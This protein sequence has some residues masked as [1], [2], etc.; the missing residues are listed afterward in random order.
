MGKTL[1]ISFASLMVSLWQL[2][3]VATGIN[4]SDEACSVSVA[5]YTINSVYQKNL[6]LLFS[7][8]SSKTSTQKFYNSTIGDDPDKVYGLY[9]C[10]E[11]VSLEICRQCI[12]EATQKIV[13][14]CPLKK[15]AIVWY[16][17]CMLRYSKSSIF[18]LLDMSVHDYKHS[19]IG[20]SN[21]SQFSPVLASE[22]D[23]VIDQAAL[24]TSSGHFATRRARWS[25]YETVYC[26]AQCTP[27]LSGRDC[28]NCL[29]IALRIMFIANFNNSVAIGIFF[30]SCQLRYGRVQFYDDLVPKPPAPTS[31]SSP[32]T[33][34][35]PGKSKADRSHILNISLGVLVAILI[36]LVALL[37]Y[38]LCT[39]RRI[40]NDSRRENHITNFK[41]VGESFMSVE[42][43]RIDVAILE[44]ATNNFSEDNKLGQGAFGGVYKGTLPN[45]V[46]I[47][48]K[49]L[50]KDSTQ[51]AEQFQNEVMFVAKLQHRNLVR[52]L[53]YCQTPDEM[54]LGYEYIPNKSLDL[55]LFD[56]ETRGLLDWSIR[57]KIIH[58]IAR[59]LQYLH[60]DS[61]LKIVH[62]DLKASNI[63][64]EADMNPKISDFGL[65]R[66]FSVNQKQDQTSRLAGTLHGCIGARA[67]HWN[68]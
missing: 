58:G 17:E 26:L 68:W 45:G 48:V 63:L 34:T 39:K 25:S 12:K 52:L 46:E 16:L 1:F 5:N 4:F 51:G 19:S 30:P 59:G 13:Q 11:D 66:K 33:M 22:M 50:S 24:S 9:Q 32:I 3:R 42:S 44:I 54:L 23:K 56:P 10:R 8:L 43:L 55:I 47:A 29:H 7:D 57:Y 38:F 21:Y 62:R 15:E 65:A 64:L 14:V 53:G 6:N 35:N 36:V 28:N 31:S 49:R 41:N 18:S 27:D 61:R 20:V 67:C 2:I 37:I 40:T 60:E